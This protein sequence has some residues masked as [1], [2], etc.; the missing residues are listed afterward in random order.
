MSEQIS[1]Y[2][3]KNERCKCYLFYNADYYPFHSSFHAT[4]NAGAL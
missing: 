2:C 4:M 3:F 1:I